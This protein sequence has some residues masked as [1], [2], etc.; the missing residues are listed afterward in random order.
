VASEDTRCSE[1]GFQQ[2]NPG[3]IPDY[4]LVFQG[5]LNARV[6]I[7]KCKHVLLP[8]SDTGVREIVPIIRG[9]TD[10][11]DSGDIVTDS[12]LTFVHTPPL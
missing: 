9:F 7:E 1:I 10:R 2:S 11:G 8:L 5:H 12:R 3:S 6:P 4:G